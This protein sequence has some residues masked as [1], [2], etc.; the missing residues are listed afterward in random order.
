[1]VDLPPGLLY[2][3]QHLP[4]LAIPPA[5]VL[6]STKLI[7]HFDLLDGVVESAIPVWAVVLA[8][9]LSLPVAFVG[10]ALLKG[11]KDR[12][13]A[14]RNGAVLPPQIYD[15]LPGGVG[16]LRATLDNFE[17]GYPGE[18]FEDWVKEYGNIVNF[19]ILG[20]DRFFTVEPDHIKAILATQFESFEKGPNF[21]RFMGSIL[22]T[23]VFNSDGDMWRFHRAMTRP[24]FTRDRIS[25]FDIF[26]RHATDALNQLKARLREGYAVDIQDLASRFTMDSATEF[27]FAKDVQS[28]AA[29]LPYPHDSPLHASTSL[30][31]STHPANKFALAFD[32]AQRLTAIRSRMGVN[33]PLAEFWRDR[34][35]KEMVTINKFIDPI[36]AAAVQRK[37]E[38]G[39]VVGEK[40]GVG[41]ER[42]VKENESLLDHLVNYTDDEKVLR[43]ETLNI[44]LAGRDTTTNSITWS[45]Y[46]LSQHPDVL[47]RLRQEILEV[48][49]ETRRPTFDDMKDMKYLRAVI[50]ETLRLYPAVPFNVRFAYSVFLMH[51]RKDLW[52]PD[53]DKFDPDRFLDSRVKTYLTPNPFIFLPFNAGPRICLGQQFAYHETSFFLIRLLQQFKRI[54]H[55]PEAQ[56]VWSRPPARWRGSAGP[57]GVDGV[58]IKSYLTM[59]VM[60]GCWVRMEEAGGEENV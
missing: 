30:A 16:L 59:S 25:H 3:I 26:D 23:G 41:G 22:G 24:F 14:A 18:L 57:K 40:V 42:E 12:R 10:K 8:S 9:A 21:Q 50:N 58:R 31:A 19:K 52:G 17:N 51:R 1:M 49:G 38:S 55:V 43:D 34:V 53:A 7:Y 29:G 4:S 15:P 28:L 44:L 6:A 47:A 13:D 5:T 45:V 35:K 20:E 2:L 46:M 56:P 33:W 32:E 60:G 37:R 36:L 48:V 27:L 39:G 54:E 11:L